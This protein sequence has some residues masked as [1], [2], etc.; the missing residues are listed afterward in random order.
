M[1]L[2]CPCNH[3]SSF[4]KVL[5]KCILMHEW[6]CILLA[7]SG[8]LAR[9]C[10]PGEQQTC[11]Q[12]HLDLKSHALITDGSSSHPMPMYDVLI[13]LKCRSHKHL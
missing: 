11:R 13:C 9:T 12:G 5:L 1:V 2:P 6:E 8:D 3:R 10:K 4:N 7:C